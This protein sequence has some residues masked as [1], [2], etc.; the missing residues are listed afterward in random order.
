MYQLR[1]ASAV[2][3]CC[4]FPSTCRLRGLNGAIQKKGNVFRF[5]ALGLLCCALAQVMFTLGDYNGVTQLVSGAACRERVRDQTQVVFEL[6]SL[7]RIVVTYRASGW[8]EEQQTTV[9]R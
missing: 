3:R 9:E 7:E 2:A 5:Q 8:R 4:G 1:R 6:H